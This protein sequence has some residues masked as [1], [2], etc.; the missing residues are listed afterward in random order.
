MLNDGTEDYSEAKEYTSEQW[1]LVKECNPESAADIPNNHVFLA[2][3]PS[4]PPYITCG[5]VPETVLL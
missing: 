3:T 1:S 4:L 5:V 2:K